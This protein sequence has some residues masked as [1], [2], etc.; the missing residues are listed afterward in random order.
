M[1]QDVKASSVE[2][3]FA[4]GNATTRIYVSDTK[5]T[6]LGS[7]NWP[8]PGYSAVTPSEQVSGDY[9]FNITNPK[10][11]RYIIIWFTSL[12][13]GT[14]QESISKVTVKGTPSG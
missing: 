11:G 12:P 14:N 9:T 7:N 2:V 13:S 5:S 1:G 10:A 4:R 8:Q 3:G 6:Q